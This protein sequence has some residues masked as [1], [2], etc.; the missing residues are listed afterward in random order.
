MATS[1]ASI[2][3]DALLFN[4]ITDYIDDRAHVVSENLAEGLGL[5]QSVV[6]KLK[7]MKN[8]IVDHME[9][10]HAD[11][12]S[13]RD[14]SQISSIPSSISNSISNRRRRLSKLQFDSAIFP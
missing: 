14:L 10:T 8:Y 3:I 12:D 4:K 11:S 1:Q 7:T 5:L 6:K 2:W 13:V 9:P